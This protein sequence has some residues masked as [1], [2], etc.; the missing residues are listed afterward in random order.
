[1][2]A[3]LAR[4]GLPARSKAS[5]S[6]ARLAAPAETSRNAVDAAAS[7]SAALISS[8]R[9]RRARPW[10]SRSEVM[11]SIHFKS[12]GA[13]TCKVPRIGHERTIS[14]RSSAPRTS[15]AREPGTRWP[16]AQRT[17]CRSWACIAVMPRTAS[18]TD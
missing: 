17:A 16:T 14:A 9:W 15:A 10:I 11:A 2:D 12:S 1:M 6:S 3:A 7:T 13:S 5:N 18:G 8:S 4:G